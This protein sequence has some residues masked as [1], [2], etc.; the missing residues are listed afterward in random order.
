MF[1]AGLLGVRLT[2][3]LPGTSWR[4][5]KADAHM[6]RTEIS[7]HCLKWRSSHSSLAWRNLIRSRGS[8]I[9]ADMRPADI[10]AEHISSPRAGHV[11][12]ST[13]L[14][15]KMWAAWALLQKQFRQL[16]CVASI[17]LLLLLYKTLYSPY[18]P[19]WFRGL[20][21]VPAPAAPFPVSCCLDAF[22]LAYVEADCRCPLHCSHTHLTAGVRQQIP[23][24]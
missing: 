6:N 20:G 21:S 11:L 3:Q 7:K 9:S 4:G 15:S 5:P 12:C 17:G 13:L 8:D 2:D 19:V 16:H 1:S 10:H 18:C 24:L 23:R 14:H 22:P